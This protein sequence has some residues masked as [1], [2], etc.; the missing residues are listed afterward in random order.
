MTI[1]RKDD[2]VFVNSAHSLSRDNVEEQF[3]EANA[4]GSIPWEVVEREV[5]A[6]AVV[7]R[8]AIR[9]TF[10]EM[11]EQ[12]IGSAVGAERARQ[13]LDGYPFVQ[14]RGIA[15]TRRGDLLAWAKSKADD[16]AIGIAERTGSPFTDVSAKSAR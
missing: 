3:P 1:G 6:D 12:Q 9:E 11:Y 2:R 16:R 13:L 10:R 8:V 5:G 14:W 15:V 4:D 7:G